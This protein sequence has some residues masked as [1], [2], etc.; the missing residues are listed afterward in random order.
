M[1]NFSLQKNTRCKLIT[2]NNISPGT[3]NY[4]LCYSK[5]NEDACN[6]I[7]NCQWSILD[8]DAYFNIRSNKIK[9]LLPKLYSFSGPYFR[10]MFVQIIAMI[11]NYF[12]LRIILIKYPIKPFLYIK[13][14]IYMF[15][16]NTTVFYVNN[17]IKE[18]NIFNLRNVLYGDSNICLVNS[19]DSVDF[20]T[21]YG[22]AMDNLSK[23][24]PLDCKNHLKN[25]DY[26]STHWRDLY[27]YSDYDYLKTDS[28]NKPIDPSDNKIKSINNIGYVVTVYS[29]LYF[30]LIFICD[31]FS[32]YKEINILKY[33]HIFVSILV[34]AI[35]YIFKNNNTINSVQKIKYNPNDPYLRTLNFF[36]DYSNLNDTYNNYFN[37]EILI[38]I[39]IMTILYSIIFHTHK[40]YD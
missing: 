18:F 31:F 29:I 24:T 20:G 12:L 15:I 9:F 38:N 17:M 26:L 32:F 1:T 25:N 22:N 8:D 37:N 4:E 34:F 33:T 39:V 30:V 3:V 13:F 36:T 7:S 6:K 2:D 19:S 14:F 23:K 40:F 35:Y 11:I 28:N 10:F 21:F 5:N 27:L 16:I